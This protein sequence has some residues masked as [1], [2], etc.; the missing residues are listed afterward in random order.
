MGNLPLS[1][2]HSTKFQ[3]HSSK[4]Q[5]TYSERRAER[6]NVLSD[7]NV[8]RILQL[9]NS[10][11]MHINSNYHHFL[12]RDEIAISEIRGKI[13][14]QRTNLEDPVREIK[15]GIFQRHEFRTPEMLRLENLGGRAQ[16]Y[17]EAM[18]KWSSEPEERR[19][20][21]ICGCDARRRRRLSSSNATELRASV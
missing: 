16:S 12:L 9:P 3:S 7:S 15:V 4:V 1:H 18:E 17:T 11:Q 10:S 5:I 20:C 14:E 19:Q 6:V 2:Q 13:R 8:T 21:S